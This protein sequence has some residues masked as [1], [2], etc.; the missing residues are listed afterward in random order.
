MA[1]NLQFDPVSIKMQ[2]LGKRRFEKQPFD[3]QALL[4]S[5]PP[6]LDFTERLRWIQTA[7]SG[8]ASEKP[9]SA[10]MRA[11]GLIALHKAEERL[12]SDPRPNPPAPARRRP[13]E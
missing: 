11:R 5:T 4:R 10:A 12:R 6:P 7:R 1:S 9:M 2:A 3:K 13:G 8:F